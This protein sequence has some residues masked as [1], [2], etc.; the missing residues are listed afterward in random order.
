MGDKFSHF[1]PSG[2]AVVLSSFEQLKSSRRAEINNIRDF[3]ILRFF[4][5]LGVILIGKQI[6]QELNLP[7]YFLSSPL[8]YDLLVYICPDAVIKDQDRQ[9]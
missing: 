4:K 1:L 6:R 9:V 2:F 5:L 8:I 7:L 3:M